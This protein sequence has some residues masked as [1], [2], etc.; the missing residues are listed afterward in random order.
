[1]IIIYQRKAKIGK[2]VMTMGGQRTVSVGVTHHHVIMT[3]NRY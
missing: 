2:I 1:M 3:D